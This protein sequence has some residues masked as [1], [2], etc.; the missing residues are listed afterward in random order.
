MLDARTAGKHGGQVRRLDDSCDV[1]IPLRNRPRCPA[2]PVAAWTRRLLG[3]R[4]LMSRAVGQ[5]ANL[6]EQIGNLPHDIDYLTVNKQPGRQ[7][8]TRCHSMT[9]G[10][11]ACR[12]CSWPTGRLPVKCPFGYD[13]HCAV[14]GFPSEIVGRKPYAVGEPG[15]ERKDPM[16]SERMPQADASTLSRPLEWLTSSSSA[17]PRSF[18][19]WPPLA[20]GFPSG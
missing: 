4:K 12:N 2:G 17:F 1:D 20:W 16:P 13:R 5:V 18:S 15:C 9:C 3:L 10:D 8:A 19:C 14:A 7:F 11:R 6:P